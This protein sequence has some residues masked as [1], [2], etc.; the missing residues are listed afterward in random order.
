MTVIGTRSPVLAI[1]LLSAALPFACPVAAQ[2]QAPSALTGKVTSQEEGAMEGV[3]VSA[4]RAGSTMTVTV[5]SNA[6]GQYSFPRDRLQPGKYAVTIRAIGYELSAPAQVDVAARQTAA[7][8]WR[9][10]R[11]VYLIDSRR[12]CVH[13]CFV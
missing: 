7:T 11:A 9:I 6:Q 10:M 4:K 1:A 8:V 3:L 2:T 5:V 13:C 12:S